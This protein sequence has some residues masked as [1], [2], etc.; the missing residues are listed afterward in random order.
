MRRI[1][2]SFLPAPTEKALNKN[3]AASDSKR[4]AGTLNVQ[5]EWNGARKTKSLTIVLQALRVMAGKRERCMYCGDSHGTDIDHFWPKTPYPEKMFIWTNLV[6]SCTECGRFKGERFPLQSAAPQLID[7]TAEDPWEFLDFDPGTGN[8]VSRYDPAVGDWKSKGSATVELLQLD[9]REAL[10]AVYQKTHLRIK[11]VVQKNLQQSPPDAITVI[12]AL[13]EADDH[14]L[15][16]W[17]FTVS[18][19]NES[20]FREFREH[21]PTVWQS[22]EAALT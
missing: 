2:R 10:A 19:A 14:G 13:R 4:I 1:T 16:G 3:Q 18:G 15:L 6:L 8:I 11:A 17:Y 5:K 9:R 22:C 20:P 12:E 7:P 21:H